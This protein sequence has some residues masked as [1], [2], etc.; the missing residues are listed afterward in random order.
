MP[1]VESRYFALPQGFAGRDNRCVNEADRL[2]GELSLQRRSPSDMTSIKRKDRVSAF[3]DP[4]AESQPRI[5]A[6]SLTNQIVQL[7]Q[8]G[9]RNDERFGCLIEEF[10]TRDM[11]L[12]VG[13]ERRVEDPCV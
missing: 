12:V 6:G 8:N 2:V 9:T 11:V 3:M 5:Y 1:P 10:H 4:V 7:D 13:I